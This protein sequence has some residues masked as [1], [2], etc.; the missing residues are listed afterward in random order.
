[1]QK[2]KKVIYVSHPY[3]GK[4]E[5]KAAIENIIKEFVKEYPY[6]TFVSPIHCFGFMY[7]KLPY[8]QG[9][10][11]CINLLE[12]CDEMWLCGDFLDSRGCRAEIKWC[13]NHLK[14]YTT[15]SMVKAGGNL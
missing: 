8:Q 15:I 4:E 14:P 10:D 9:L 1:M 3:G 2:A 6:Y 7:D 11:M 13:H 12:K 5:N